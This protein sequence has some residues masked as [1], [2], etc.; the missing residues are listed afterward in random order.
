MRY[1][2]RLIALAVTL[3]LVNVVASAQSDKAVAPAQPDKVEASYLLGPDDVLEIS[4]LN[5]EGLNKTLS[6][7]S[8]GTITYPW[9]GQMK[10]SGKTPKQL[11]DEIRAELEKTRNNVEVTVAVTDPLSR[12]VRVIGAV[13]TPG[14]YELKPNWRFL[15]VVGLAGGLTVRPALVKARIIRDGT[16]PIALDPVKS[17]AA[18]DSDANPLLQ[19]GDLILLDDADP[20]GNKVYVMGQVP[21]PGAYVPGDDGIGVLSLLSQAGNPKDTAALSRSYVLRGTTQ[22]PVDLRSLVVGGKLDDNARDMKLQAGDVLVIPEIDQRVAVMGQVNKP[23]YYDLPETRQLTA[24]DALS[25]AGGQSQTGDLHK[26]GII[27]MVSNKAVVIPV[28]IEQM[29][30]KGKLE[31]NIPLQPNDVLFIPARGTTQS[32]TMKDVVAPITALLLLGVRLFP[33]L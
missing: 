3:L 6:V 22:I 7:L 4:V 15:D 17:G 18:P 23:G 26:A 10:A 32:S 8:D 29:L 2:A 12:R 28:D 33:G 27:R 1:L 25:M 24:V 13:K 14:P 20:A 21:N 19:P 30:Q 5:H 31:A 11:A 16:K 9:V